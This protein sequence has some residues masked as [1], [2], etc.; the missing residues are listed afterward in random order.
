MCTT[1]YCRAT[2]SDLF[3]SLVPKLNASYYP[4]NCGR[5]LHNCHKYAKKYHRRPIGSPSP[6][7]SSGAEVMDLRRQKSCRVRSKPMNKPPGVSALGSPRK[8]AR[9]PARWETVVPGL[10]VKPKVN[11]CLQIFFCTPNE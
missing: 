10:F 1:R 11:A 2:C 7:A 4:P 8:L 5:L 3:G 9:V 6:A